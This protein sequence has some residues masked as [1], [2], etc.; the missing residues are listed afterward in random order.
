M[1]TNNE[2]VRV[3]YLMVYAS[4]VK[5]ADQSINYGNT[6]IKWIS[7]HKWLAAMIGYATILLVIGATNSRHGYY[8]RQFLR[9]ATR[10]AIDYIKS[11]D[12]IGFNLIKKWF[13]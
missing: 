4:N 2:I 3:R 7:R 5:K 9:Q 1:I 8:I 10:N 6:M 11:L 12:F 13:D